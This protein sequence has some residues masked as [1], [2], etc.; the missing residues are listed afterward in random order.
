[1]FS[2]FVPLPLFPALV[3]MFANNLCHVY[4]LFSAI[5][6]AFKNSSYDK[7]SCY[8]QP[9]IKLFLQIYP[10]S[11]KIGVYHVNRCLDWIFVLTLWLVMK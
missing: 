9:L 10:I 1:M 5:F 11:L 4:K 6:V 3:K 7:H 2:R 8:Y